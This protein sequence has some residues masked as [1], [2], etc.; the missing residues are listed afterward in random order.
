MEF[1]SSFVRWNFVKD[2]TEGFNHWGIE[3]IG[4]LRIEMGNFAFIIN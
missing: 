4:G 1:I 3:I 2:K